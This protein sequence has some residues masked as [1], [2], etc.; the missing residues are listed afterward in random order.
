MNPLTFRQ[1]IDEPTMAAY[2]YMTDAMLPDGGGMVR[3]DASR[4]RPLVTLAVTAGPLHSTMNFTADQARAVAA[5]L[6]AAATAM[7]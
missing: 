4:Y 3:I 2:A 7:G 1:Y 5:E 6:L